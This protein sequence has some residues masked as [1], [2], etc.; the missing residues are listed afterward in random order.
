[1]VVVLL[2]V[3]FGIST[4]KAHNSS[5]HCLVLVL[6]IVAWTT[7]NVLYILIHVRT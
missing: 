7:L 6:C 1:M 4:L 5:Q 2:A 3:L